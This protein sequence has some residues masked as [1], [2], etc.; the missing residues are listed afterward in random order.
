[1]TTWQEAA[2]DGIEKRNQQPIADWRRHASPLSLV[3]F[4]A[5][6]ALGLSGLL[7]HERD[8]TASGG[9]VDVRIHAPEV[10][11]NGEFLE[12]R[13]TLE[14]DGPLAAPAIGLD[15]ALWEDMTV[16]TMIPAA[17]TETSAGGELRFEFEP[18]EAG[19]P[20]LW[21]VD[22]QVN[23]DTVGG[24]AGTVT[25]YDGGDRLVSADVSIDVLP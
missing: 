1:M 2:P 24:N 12:L 4:G 25:I 15:A 23:P 16:N 10:I 18:I 19:V 7:G 3:V 6:V 20:F 11:R 21:K 5:V 14:S 13:V 9:G 17:T 22:M 8:W